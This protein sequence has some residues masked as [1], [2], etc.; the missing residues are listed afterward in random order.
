MLASPVSQRLLTTARTRPGITL[1][2]AREILNMSWGSL[3]RHLVRLEQ[4]GLVRLQTAGRRRLLFPTGEVETVVQPSVMEAAASL[5]QPT[6]RM[7]ATAII[8]RPGRSVPEIAH[9]LQLTPRVVY[10]HVQRLLQ[11]GLIASSS[12]TRHRDLT[13]TPLLLVALEKVLG[14]PVAAPELHTHP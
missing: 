7:I 12:Q 13:P 14:Q 1:S 6:S 9:S 3:Y 11:M 5:R 8:L 2:E 10:H 4:A